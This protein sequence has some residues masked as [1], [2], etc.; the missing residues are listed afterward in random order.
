MGED[1]DKED[2]LQDFE[3][4]VFLMILRLFPCEYITQYVCSV[5][6]KTWIY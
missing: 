1:I 6:T 3:S 4:V 2:C 5:V